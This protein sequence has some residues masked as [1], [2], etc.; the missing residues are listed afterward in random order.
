MSERSITT[1]GATTNLA[2]LRQIGQAR[3]RGESVVC[4]RCETPLT[5]FHL[6]HTCGLC[7]CSAVDNASPQ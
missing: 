4:W 6:C 5:L 7:R 1:R 2:S 3:E